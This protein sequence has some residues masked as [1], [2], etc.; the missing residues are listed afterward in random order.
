LLSGGIEQRDRDVNS[1]LQ[2]DDV[3]ELARC[4]VNLVGVLFATAHFA[5]D[6]L[7]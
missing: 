7:A 5:F 2:H 3:N 6:G 4:G 1:F